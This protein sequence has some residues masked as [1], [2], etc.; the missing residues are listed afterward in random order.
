MIFTRF[1]CNATRFQLFRNRSITIQRGR[2]VIVIG[3]DGVNI[4]LLRQL[5]NHF[6]CGA[7]QHIQTTAQRLK[8]GTKLDNTVPDEFNPTIC[9]VDKRIE[10]FAI[11]DEH[12]MQTLRLR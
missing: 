11:K 1:E 6:A 8:R 9:L 7:V 3:E 2:L 10:N 5:W 12:A 4:Q